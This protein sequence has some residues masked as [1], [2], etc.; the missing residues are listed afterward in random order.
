M[1]APRLPTAAVVL[2]MALGWKALQSGRHASRAAAIWVGVLLLVNLRLIIPAPLADPRVT[3]LPVSD[4]AAVVA[5]TGSDV[6]LAD[7]GRYPRQAALLAADS[8]YRRL[9]AVMLSHTD[10]DHIGGAVHILRTLEVEQLIFPSWMMSAVE[11]VPLL[12]AARSAGTRVVP[13]ARGSVVSAGA[14][15]V[16]VVWPP[17]LHPP[18]EENERS[19]VARIDVG[20]GTV[21]VTADIG[22]ATERRLALS[23]RLNCDVLVTPHHGSRSGSSSSLLDA[24]APT[25]ALVPAAPGNTHGHPHSEVLERLAARGIVVRIPARDEPAGARWNGHRWQAFP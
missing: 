14:L 16:E 23:S 24:A 11:T 19:L 21:V 15:R 7:A 6:F 5:A 3:V 22:R 10:E 9:K 4:G 13:V 17:A 12:R 25:I 20:P 8:D 18:R 1:I 2:L